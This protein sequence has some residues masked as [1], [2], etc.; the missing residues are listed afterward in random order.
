[1]FERYSKRSRQVILIALWSARR[2]GG[3]YIEP[4]DLLHALVREDRR[5]IGTPWAEI[6]PGSP[7]PSAESGGARPFFTDD[8]AQNLLTALEEPSKGDPAAKG[9]MPVSHSLQ[10]LLGLA[11][12]IAQRKDTK[13]IVPI[14]LLAAIVKDRE[15]KLAQLLLDH[16]VTRQKVAQALDAA[17][18]LQ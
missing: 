2:R 5:D 8:T 12:K 1:M 4:E 16:G 6:F 15:S 18:D 3:S 9:D 17:P 7:A 14:H 10:D 11:A 13:T